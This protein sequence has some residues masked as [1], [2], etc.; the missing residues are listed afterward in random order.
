MHLFEL[1]APASLEARLSG[2]LPADPTRAAAI[3]HRR[4]QK[5]GTSF[6]RR[7]AT[8]YQGVTDAWSLGITKIP[9]VVVDRHYVVYGVPDVDRAISLIQEYRSKQR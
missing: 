4:L 1:D 8:A 7:L 6:Q 3:V 5:G 9:A 2:R